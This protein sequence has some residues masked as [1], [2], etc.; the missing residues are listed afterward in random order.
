[1]NTESFQDTSLTNYMLNMLIMFIMSNPLPGTYVKIVPK[2]PNFVYLTRDQT[3]LYVLFYSSPLLFR[4]FSST[5][6]ASPS[7]EFSCILDF[8]CGLLFPYLWYW[9]WPLALIQNFASWDWP[10]CF[11]L[12]V[13]FWGDISGLVFSRCVFLS[14]HR[15]V[16]RGVEMQ[17]T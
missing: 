12:C 10:G 14:T 17:G 9:W 16:Q 8:L 1:M 2:A 5:S 15:Q 6:L 13:Y 4:K 11:F 7:S 3:L